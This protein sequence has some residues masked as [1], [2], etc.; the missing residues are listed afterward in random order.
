MIRE[1]LGQDNSHSGS[2]LQERD[3]NEQQLFRL[4]TSAVSGR[5]ENSA[6]GCPTRRSMKRGELSSNPR[7]RSLVKLV[8]NNVVLVAGETAV[9]GHI[10]YSTVV[11]GTRKNLSVDSSVNVARRVQQ[12]LELPSSCGCT[13]SGDQTILCGVYVNNDDLD[14]NLCDQ[15]NM[16]RYACEEMEDAILPT[17]STATRAVCTSDIGAGERDVSEETEYASDA[18]HNHTIENQFDATPDWISFGDCVHSKQNEG[19]TSENNT[20]TLHGTR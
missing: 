20:C 19:E 14:V 16:S 11:A 2:P 10:D 7:A 5:S 4:Y 13:M 6:T 15:R 1:V 12:E 9:A 18:H 8:K 3:R 17:H